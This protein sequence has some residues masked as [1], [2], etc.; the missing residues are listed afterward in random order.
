MTVGPSNYA[1][2]T[3]IAT[4][5][6]GKDVTGNLGETCKLAGTTAATCTATGGVTVGPISTTVS[7]VETLS[8][9]RYNRFDVMITAGAEKISNPTACAKPTGGA[10]SLN[11]RNMAVWALAG[12]IGVANFLAL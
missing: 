12:A 4:S 3:A 9:L 7:A 1:I 8:G 2:S 10:G 11:P 5:T 6:L